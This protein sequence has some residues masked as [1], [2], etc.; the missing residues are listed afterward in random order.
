M[1]IAL[2]WGPFLSDILAFPFLLTYHLLLD[3]LHGIDLSRP[4]SQSTQKQHVMRVGD[5]HTRGEKKREME[6][7]QAAGSKAVGCWW[8]RVR[9]GRRK[10]CQRLHE[11]S[12]AT[13]WVAGRGVIRSNTD[14]I[15]P[16]PYS[17]PHSTF[18]YR[19]RYYRMWKND[20]RIRQNQILDTCRIL[21][22]QMILIGYEKTDTVIDKLK[23]RDWV[24][25]RDWGERELGDW[26]RESWERQ[27]QRCHCRGLT[28]RWHLVVSCSLSH[29]WVKVRSS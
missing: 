1:K 3:P 17:Y 10:W 11:F 13:L 25:E 27:R 8:S 15:F 9:R 5:A 2:L 18:G 16:L 29:D 24:G 6:A 22:D 4:A 28:F 12:M 14:W 7:R 26:G 19:Y 23:R 20:I 21:T